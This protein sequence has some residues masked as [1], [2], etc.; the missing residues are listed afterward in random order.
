MFIRALHVALLL[1]I[2]SVSLAATP[3][4]NLGGLKEEK[5]S[6]ENNKA[7]INLLTGNA[8]LTPQEI[9]DNDI[10]SLQKD[11]A[12]WQKKY[13]ELRAI[14]Q[15]YE[16]AYDANEQKIYEY[17]QEVIQLKA[18]LEKSTE[19]ITIQSEFIEMK[20][21]LVG[22]PTL[23]ADEVVSFD[24][25]NG[26]KIKLIKHIVVKGETLTMIALKS[27]NGVEVTKESLKFRKDTIQNIN[28][29]LPKKE[30][31]AADTVVY[32]PFFK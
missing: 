13:D 32:V 7:V 6:K 27:F 9:L 18:E 2:C 31:Q 23:D 17:E 16:A 21:K 30:Q 14:K 11:I 20:Q 5:I 25:P 1:G 26:D 10:K 29:H 4:L 3:N 22:A 24:L 12:K 8:N 28:S 19:K 15:E